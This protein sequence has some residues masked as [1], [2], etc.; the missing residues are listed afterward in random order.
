L[1]NNVILPKHFPGPLHIS[2][3][4]QNFLMGEVINPQPWNPKR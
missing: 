4:A 2:L 3:K 1:L